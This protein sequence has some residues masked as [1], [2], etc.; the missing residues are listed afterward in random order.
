MSRPVDN[1]QAAG[2]EALPAWTPTSTRASGTMAF[3]AVGLA[4]LY[5]FALFV[6]LSTTGAYIG[7]GLMLLAA[8]GERSIRAEALR[9]PLLRIALVMATYLLLHATFAVWTDAA[10]LHDVSKT[11]WMWL[12]PL[13]ILIVVAW[14]L[15]GNERRIGVAL[16]LACLGLALRILLRIETIGLTPFLNGARFGFGLQ[17]TLFGL[18]ASTGL[19][20]LL[21]LSPRVLKLPRTRPG[22]IFA[23]LGWCAA[24]IVVGQGLIVSQTRNAWL[25][26]LL[27]CPLMLA[28]ILIRGR[29]IAPSRWKQIGSIGLLTLTL[30]VTVTYNW[31]TIENRLFAEPIAWQALFDGDLDHM[32]ATGSIG[33]RFKLWELAVEKW[34]DRPVFGWGPS[35]SANLIRHSNEQELSHLVHFHSTY[36]EILV[37]LGLVGAGLF[38]AVGT[39]LGK[40]LYHAWRSNMMPLDY[41]LFALGASG[42]L[43]I[44]AASDHLVWTAAWKPHFGLMTAVIYGYRY[45]LLHT[46]LPAGPITPRP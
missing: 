39:L 16:A 12:K 14:W 13:L 26:L 36:L 35:A 20:G 7:L 27:I 34:R 5:L 19:L 9:D 6:W 42:L 32:P 45:R 43:L 29:G 2:S 15:Q 18:F 38:L 4:G 41:A 40:I 23:A 1:L 3:T 46:R 30:G 31:K 8:L 33:A 22:L 44:S 24:V 21:V 10:S 17:I 37:G 25:A 11:S 28:I